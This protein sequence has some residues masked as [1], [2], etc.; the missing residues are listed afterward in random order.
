MLQLIRSEQSADSQ[1][2][3]KLSPE[4]LELLEC[5]TYRQI[6]GHFRQVS[7]ASFQ[8]AKS[9][10][11]LDSF[12]QNPLKKI[13]LAYV[14]QINDLKD[15]L[16]GLTQVVQ[17]AEP[18]GQQQMAAPVTDLGLVDEVVGKVITVLGP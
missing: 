18:S 9:L 1:Q 12:E 15:V 3:A 17:L 6:I 11:S 2:A 10:L 5:S 13:A 8:G 14:G 16:A 4:F 7:S